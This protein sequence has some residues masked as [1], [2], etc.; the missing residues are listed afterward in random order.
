MALPAAL[1]FTATELNAKVAKLRSL[2]SQRGASAM[3]IR[4]Q[5]NF[6]WIT[7]GRTFISLASEM[8]CGQI[9]VTADSVHLFTN[10]IEAPRLA[11]EELPAGHGIS[12]HASAWHEPKALAAAVAE[13]AGPSPL[14]EEAAGHDLMLMR[15]QLNKTEMKR[16]R[17]LSRN[18][19]KVVEAACRRLKPGQTEFAI[20]GQVSSALWRLGIEPIT[21]MVAADERVAKYRHPIPT[22]RP[23][24]RYCMIVV[25]SR[26]FGLITNVTRLVHFGPVSTDLANR[27]KAVTMVDTCLNVLTRP[28]AKVSEIFQQAMQAYATAGYAD[29]WKLHHQ[30]G[31]TGYSAR[32]YTGTPTSQETVMANQAFAWNPS[33]A[34]VKSEDTILVLD[35]GNEVITNTGNYPYCEVTFG[36]QSMQRPDILVR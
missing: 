18:T 7:G 3:T 30:G 28:G 14:T 12:V 34:G 13:V 9:V 21:I 36:G 17:W 23:V 35:S 16:F 1:A 4:S 11:D 10:V 25:C 20:A 15:S 24:E 33:I 22:A 5:A 2:M 8:A 32:E 19:A 27:M 6:S 26:R 31:L 29:E